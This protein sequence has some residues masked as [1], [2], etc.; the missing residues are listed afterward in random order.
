MIAQAAYRT[1]FSDYAK[2]VALPS[3]SPYCRLSTGAGTGG[4][5]QTTI[6]VERAP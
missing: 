2:D 5:E 1:S 4:A 6:D 3:N